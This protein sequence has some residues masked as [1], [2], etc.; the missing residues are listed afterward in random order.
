MN[1]NSG[2]IIKKKCRV[3]MLTGSFRKMKLKDKTRSFIRVQNLLLVIVVLWGFSGCGHFPGAQGAFENEDSYNA[4]W[5]T[6]QR[7]NKAL[8]NG[9]YEKALEIYRMLSQLARQDKIRRMALYG[10]ACVQLIRAEDEAEMETS[11]TLWDTWSGLVQDEV[12]GED[13]RLLKDLLEQKANVKQSEANPIVL[14]PKPKSNP[15]DTKAIKEKDKEIKRLKT[16]IK[17][18][19]SELRDLAYQLECLEAIDQKIQE[20]KKDIAL[21]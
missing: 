1:R 15:P 4:D 21:P 7:G 5:I 17:S 20:K 6:L 9:H 3:A 8:R 12:T 13:P 19:K 2:G 14:E 11:I 18:L 10:M 16:Q